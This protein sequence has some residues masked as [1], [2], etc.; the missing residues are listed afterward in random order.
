MGDCDTTSMGCGG[1]EPS[2]AYNYLIQAGGQ[3]SEAAYPYHAV[4]QQCAFNA[5]DVRLRIASWKKA[6]SWY[7]ES[8]LHS[9]LAAWGP[10]SICVDAANWQHYKSGVM[11]RFQ[12]AVV[13][14]LDH[15]VQLVG[16]ALNA[17]TPYW[18][19]RNSWGTGWGLSGYIR[20]EYGW[21]VCGIANQA[22]TPV[23]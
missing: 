6:T 20:L 2:S 17:T 12:C 9:N 8:T 10:L 5:S 1:G 15:C 22:T 4:N 19:V 21:D 3:E 14:R 23:V 7:S 18:Q 13:N 11:D 16:I